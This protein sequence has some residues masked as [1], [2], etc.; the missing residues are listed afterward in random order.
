LVASTTYWCGSDSSATWAASPAAVSSAATDVAASRAA[1]GGAHRRVEGE[2][3]HRERAARPQ[4]GGEL[5]GVAR[6]IG[7]VVPGVD[8][9]DPIDA[10]GGQAGI[11][12]RPPAR[13]RCST[14]RRWR[15]SAMCATIAGS[16]S[17]ARILPAPPT[18]RVR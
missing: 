18:A 9:Q 7:Q 10:G 1:G 15:A 8:D 16:L 3:D 13:P 6:A 12:G 11:V 4:R 2:V 5:G 17:S 14:A